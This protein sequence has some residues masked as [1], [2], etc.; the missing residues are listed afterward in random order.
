MDV[1]TSSQNVVPTLESTEHAEAVNHFLTMM[2]KETEKPKPGLSNEAKKWKDA[3]KSDP[4]NMAY[5]AQLGAAYADERQWQQCVSVMMRGWKRVGEFE[6]PRAALEFLCLLAQGSYEV[7]KYK[8]ALA[9]IQDANTEMLVGADESDI[10]HYHSLRCQVLCANQETQKA[11]K[12]F[13]Q[14]VERP[15]FELCAGTWVSCHAALKKAGLEEATR[16][17]LLAKA[18]NDDERQLLKA[19]ETVALAKS[20][21]R[22]ELE[23]PAAFFPTHMRSAA[24]VCISLVATL[25]VYGLYILEQKSFASIKRN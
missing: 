9:V 20:R 16:S 8:Q 2:H 23:K 19:M 15:S 22:E 24:Y 12:A 7:K 13:H 11:L 18:A 25:L 6:Q 14:A 1:T 5:I 3:L 4:Y 10:A 17:I 21:Y